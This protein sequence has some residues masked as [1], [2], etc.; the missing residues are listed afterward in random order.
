MS[1]KDQEVE[2]IVQK[3]QTKYVKKCERLEDEIKDLKVRN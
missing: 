2:G 3:M 1:Q